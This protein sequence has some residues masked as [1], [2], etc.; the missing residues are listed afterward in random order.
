MSNKKTKIKVPNLPRNISGLRNDGRRDRR[1][2]KGTTFA[3]MKKRMSEIS[4]ISNS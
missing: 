3:E 4:G 1:F 2:K